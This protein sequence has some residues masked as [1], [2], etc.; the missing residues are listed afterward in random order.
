MSKK[1]IIA[2]AALALLAVLPSA[3]AQENTPF[4]TEPVPA[5]ATG[6]AVPGEATP[7]PT[8]AAPAP[9][10]TEEEQMKRSAEINANYDS[11]IDIYGDVLDRQETDTKFIDRRIKN[12]QEMVKDFEPKLSESEQGM[13]ALRVAHTNRL[14]EIR[15]Q[16]EQGLLNEDQFKAAVADE[17]AR[18]ERRV[19]RF[20]NE[21]G[22][23][24]GESTEAQKRI[25]ELEAE[26]ERRVQEQQMRA[27]QDPSKADPTKATYDGIFGTLDQLSGFRVKLTMDDTAGLWRYDHLHG[28]R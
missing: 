12:N 5:T 11:T 3:Q 28:A 16:K 23:Y 10:L 18:Y 24:G 17:N 26:R 15:R 25:T 8:P 19:A 27:A 22:F 9:P 21:V 1:T 2:L 4:P 14:L 7:A 13:R 20:K 6:E